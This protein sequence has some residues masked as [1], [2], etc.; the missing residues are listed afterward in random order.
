MQRHFQASI[1]DLSYSL[2]IATV[3]RT[4]VNAN[5]QIVIDVKVIPQGVK[6]KIK[7]VT[8]VRMKL[9]TILNTDFSVN[10]IVGESVPRTLPDGNIAL[11][12]A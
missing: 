10:P 9:I 5:K 4:N 11:R 12:K 3:E 1:N 8:D 2:N 7:A 6:F